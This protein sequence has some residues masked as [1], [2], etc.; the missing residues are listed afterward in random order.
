MF[1]P[2]TTPPPVPRSQT[3]SRKL[4]RPGI[5]WGNMALEDLVAYRDQIAQELNRRGA[6]SLADMSIETELMLQYQ[7]LRKLQTDTI[8]D[9]GTPANQKAQVAN[10]VGSVLARLA[11]LQVSVHNSERVKKIETAL[12]KVLDRLPETEAKAFLDHYAALLD[13]D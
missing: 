7:A 3:E 6:S 5:S 10:S 2:M 13:L 4:A 12:G 1:E 11:D 9:T 8:E